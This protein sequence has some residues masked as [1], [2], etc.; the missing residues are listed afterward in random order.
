MSITTNLEKDPYKDSLC[1]PWN[2]DL[3]RPSKEEAHDKMHKNLLKAVKEHKAADYYGKAHYLSSTDPWGQPYYTSS[4]DPFLFSQEEPGDP[5]VL[6]C[7]VAQ[8]KGLTSKMEDAHLVLV[9]EKG[10]L[11]GI[12]DGHS[13]DKSSGEQSSGAK[14]AN[15]IR[16]YLELNF[17]LKLK[18]NDDNIHRTFEELIHAIQTL[19][20][21]KGG[22]GFT[23]G[24]QVALC[25]TTSNGKVYTATLGDSEFF[26]YRQ[27]EGFSLRQK[28]IIS[29]WKVIPLSCVRDFSNQKEAARA[30]EAC[31]WTVDDFQ[32]Q[33]AEPPHCEPRY[34]RDF[35]FDDY[36]PPRIPKPKPNRFPPFKG[37][38][39]SRLIGDEWL[40]VYIKSCEDLDPVAAKKAT[41]HLKPLWHKPKITEFTLKPGDLIVGGSNPVWDYMHQYTILRILQKHLEGSLAQKIVDEA[42]SVHKKKGRG[43]NVTVITAEVNA[44]N[45]PPPSPRA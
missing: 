20:S 33:V 29:E 27:Q 6:K 32:H 14:L 44:V 34:L 40:N 3:R 8:D 31:G 1:K 19:V 35:E 18:E 9:N 39:M 2:P 30:A 26:A 5:L 24:S 12:F 17:F 16:E 23:A 21:V 43:H 41:E 38:N 7:Q 11:L 28:K 37:V 36:C 42:I 15:Y 13:S 25:Y 22:L 10:T 4:T 45:P